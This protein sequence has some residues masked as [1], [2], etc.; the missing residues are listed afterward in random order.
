VIERRMAAQEFDDCRGDRVG[1][2]LRNHRWACETAVIKMPCMGC[3]TPRG[4][5]A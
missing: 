5:G 4:S 2:R 3:V 1:G